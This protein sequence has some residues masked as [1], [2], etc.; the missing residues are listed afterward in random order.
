MTRRAAMLR[1]RTRICPTLRLSIVAKISTLPLPVS[2]AFVC[3][4]LCVCVSALF[5]QKCMFFCVHDA[6]LHVCISVCI[7]GFVWCLCLRVSFYQSCFVNSV[8][9]NDTVYAWGYNNWGQLA[10]NSAGSTP[11]TVP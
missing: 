8:T 5:C 2:D 6:C 3:V 10:I 9:E 4:C 1:R 7:C 11:V